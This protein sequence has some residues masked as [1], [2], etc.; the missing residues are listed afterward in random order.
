MRMK[1]VV[2]TMLLSALTL[3]IGVGPAL[4]ADGSGL[5]QNDG[6][7]QSFPGTEFDL[8]TEIRDQAIALLLP[9]VQSA[10]EAPR[11]AAP[12]IPTFDLFGDG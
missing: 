9:A 11:R 3:G 4:A 10:R 12:A 6:S 7:A 8:V 1:R 5:D 2:A